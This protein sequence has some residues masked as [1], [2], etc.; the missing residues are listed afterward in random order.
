MYLN[1]DLIFKKGRGEV[2]MYNCDP[3]RDALECRRAGSGVESLES[4]WTSGVR[5]YSSYGDKEKVL[6]PNDMKRLHNVFEEFKPLEKTLIEYLIK[7][8]VIGNNRVRDHKVEY[9]WNKEAL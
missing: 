8:V 7:S 1:G 9:T 4:L 6:Y 2:T 5:S 3:C